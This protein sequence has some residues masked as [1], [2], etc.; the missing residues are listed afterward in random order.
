LIVLNNAIAN[1]SRTEEK[2]EIA[3]L[4]NTVEVLLLSDFGKILNTF[5]LPVNNKITVLDSAITE[6]YQKLKATKLKKELKMRSFDDDYITGKDWLTTNQNQ[7]LI[8]TK[9]FVSI[10]ENYSEAKMSQLTSSF[11]TSLNLLTFNTKKLQ[12]TY[13]QNIQKT[14][15]NAFYFASL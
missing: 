11:E 6:I 10:L 13:L 2:A 9:R 5:Y 14:Y 12:S 4:R 1:I 15:R 7:D 8:F 3:C